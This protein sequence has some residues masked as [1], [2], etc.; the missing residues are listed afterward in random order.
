MTSEYD[1][2]F[3]INQSYN[4]EIIYINDFNEEVM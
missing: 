3:E 1:D 2:A 4:F